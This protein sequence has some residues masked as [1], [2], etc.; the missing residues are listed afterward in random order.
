MYVQPQQPLYNSNPMK[1]TLK[2][3]KANRKTPVCWEKVKNF[4][5]NIWNYIKLYLEI[6]C[7]HCYAYL[8]K[9]GLTKLERIFWLIL[10]IICHYFCFFIAMQAITRFMNKNSYVGIERNYFDWNTTLPSVTICPMERLNHEKFND[11]CEINDIT[12]EHKEEFFDFLEHLANST[13]FNFQDIPHHRTVEGTLDRLAIKPNKYMELIYNLTADETMNPNEKQR[14]RTVD[15]G[16]NIHTRQI[17]TEYGLCYMTNS[18][19]PNEYTSRYLIFGEYPDRN[20]YEEEAQVRPVQQ[21]SFPD[22]YI[23]FNFIGFQSAMDF[24]GH[25][26]F[27]VMKVDNNFGYTTENLYYEPTVTEITTDTNF[28]FGANIRQRNCR[29]NHESNLTHFPVYTKNLCM[30]ECR[31]QLVYKVCKCIPHFYPN[32]FGSVKRVCD[33]KTLRECFPR[34]TA[35]FLKMYRTVAHNKIEDIAPCYCMQNCM[36]SVIS[37]RV[38]FL[39]KTKEFF[40]GKGTILSMKEWPTVRFK[41]QIIFTNTDLMVSIGGTAGLFLGFSVLG[42]IEM[43]YFFTMRLLFNLLGYKLQ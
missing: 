15:N 28:E 29:F 14:V 24:Y 25:S 19:L 43:V 13:Y 31:L 23:D 9:N 20:V 3:K 39:T 12:G 36:N 2:Q 32:R 5:L 18:F 7:V 40:G 17:L 21:G 27:D 8:V 6:C 33:Y 42:A 35:Y 1:Q 22:K 4:L 37:L 11:F 26:A 16:A 34:H 38:S 10:M 30:Q 41:R